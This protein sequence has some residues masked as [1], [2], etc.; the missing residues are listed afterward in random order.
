MKKLALVILSMIYVMIFYMT[1]DYAHTLPEW[2]G[3]A[4][5]GVFIILCI[6][7]VLVD[8]ILIEHYAEVTIEKSE[9]RSLY[10]IKKY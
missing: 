10:G 8:K 4:L 2:A 1:S 7:L 6:G 9:K 3:M 5:C